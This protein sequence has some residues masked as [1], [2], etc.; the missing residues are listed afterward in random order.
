MTQLIVDEALAVMPDDEPCPV[1]RAE[2]AATKLTRKLFDRNISIGITIEQC[3]SQRID[4]LYR[5]ALLYICSY[6]VKYIDTEE[7]VEEEPELVAAGADSEPEA[8]PKRK[9]TKKS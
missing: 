3:A 9:R 5:Y 7:Q 6:V 8:K 4:M 1:T 2:V